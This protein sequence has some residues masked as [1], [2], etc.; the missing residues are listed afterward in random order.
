M[1]AENNPTGQGTVLGNSATVTFGQFGGKTIQGKVD[2]GAT[3]SSLHATEISVQGNRVSFKCPV[4]SNNVLT[5]GLEGSQEVHS[6]DAGG[7]DRP[8]V[9]IDVEVD[10]VSLPGATFNLN[11]RSGMDTPILIGQNILKAGNFTIDPNKQ[12]DA[13]EPEQLAQ[14]AVPVGESKQDRESAVLEAIETLSVHNVTLSEI[15]EYLRTAA[16]NRI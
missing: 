16:V 2:T 1:D 4:L 10:G 12:S 11:D 7:V 8:I 14:P 13:E 5:L 15:V 9:K 3:T 6:A